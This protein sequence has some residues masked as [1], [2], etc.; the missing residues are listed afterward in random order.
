MQPAG[1][2]KYI[3]LLY[4][5][6]CLES[7]ST[8]CARRE[9]PRAF[10]EPS[11]PAP[12]AGEARGPA[13]PAAA[14]LPWSPLLP[15][16]PKCL[17]PLLHG[18]TAAARAPKPQEASN[19]RLLKLDADGEA[20]ALSLF[21]N[22]CYLL[23]CADPAA[24]PHPWQALVPKSLFAQLLHGNTKPRSPQPPWSPRARRAPRG[25]GDGAK[26][27]GS[28]H[29]P[30]VVNVTG[31]K[32]EAA[33]S[34]LCHHVVTRAPWSVCEPCQGW[35]GGGTEHPAPHSREGRY[36]GCSRAGSGVKNPQLLV[37]VR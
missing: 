9:H 23:S 7:Q 21:P 5:Y 27:P 14:L 35:G 34:P 17:P 25:E 28:A 15:S 16:P 37:L 32:E 29:Q 2:C 30:H 33:P 26:A 12:G 31:A 18:G 1:V 6:G 24:Q 11:T 19:K 22:H 4:L 3:L 20:Q 10:W 8:S 13:E 36:L